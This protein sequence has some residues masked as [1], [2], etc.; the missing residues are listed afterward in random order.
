MAKQ[1][2]YF[3]LMLI[4][5]LDGFGGEWRWKDIR[6]KME[7]AS[8][9]E[10]IPTDREEFVSD[11]TKVGEGKVEPKSYF[12]KLATFLFAQGL[13]DN[14]QINLADL[15]DVLIYPLIVEKWSE[16]K[17]VFKPDNHFLEA[18]SKTNNYVITKNDIEHLPA[19]TFYLDLDDYNKTYHGAFVNIIAEEK[20]VYI[21]IYSMCKTDCWFSHYVHCGY[22]EENSIHSQEL[23]KLFTNDKENDEIIKLD[24]ETGIYFREHVTLGDDL[25]VNGITKIVFQLLLYLTSKEPDVKESENTKRTYRKPVG[26]PKNTFKEVQIFDVGV[27]Y[28][29]TIKALIQTE[30]KKSHNNSTDIKYIKSGNKRRSPRLHFRCAHWQRYR[31]GK[32]RT[33]VITKWI[34]PVFV[35]AG[36]STDVVIHKVK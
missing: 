19:Y 35:G 16:N 32:G 22:D 14:Q 1:S 18:L 15:K 5:G 34:E 25:T 3:P 12:K 11:V 4:N 9:I 36:N 29:K 10:N 28:G 13:Y 8:K 21:T 6:K 31:V 7:E 26:E 17:Q 27:R 20:D 33:E 24:T 2:H 30:K 23:D